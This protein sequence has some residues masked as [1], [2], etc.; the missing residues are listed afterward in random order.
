M[1][2]GFRVS[3]NRDSLLLLGINLTSLY[4]FSRSSDFIMGKLFILDEMKRV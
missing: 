4:T 1:R 2:C 3:T